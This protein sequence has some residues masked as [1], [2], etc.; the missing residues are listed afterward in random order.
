METSEQNKKI[1]NWNMLHENENDRDDG[2]IIF[3]NILVAS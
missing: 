2:E 3:R 1:Y